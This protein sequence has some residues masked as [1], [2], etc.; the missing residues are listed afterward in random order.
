MGAL[1][2]LRNVVHITLS[3]FSLIDND[4]LVKFPTVF[5][6]STLRLH[7]Y[8][9]DEEVIKQLLGCSLSLVEFTVDV[10]DDDVDWV[11]LNCF[12]HYGC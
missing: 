1:H 2:H 10:G 7:A 5:Y 4:L 11:Q 3:D 6:W 9:W 8:M 12:Q